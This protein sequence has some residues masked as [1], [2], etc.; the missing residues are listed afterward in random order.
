MEFVIGL[1][2]TEYENF[3][4]NHK[5][6]SHFL[7]SYYW[8]EISKEKNFMP[9]YV[10][11]KIDNVLVAAALILEKNPKGRATFFYIPRGYVIDFNNKELL[12]FFTDNIKKLAKKRHAF[13]IRIDPDVKLHNLDQ[14]GKVVD[15][16]NNVDLVNYLISL[17]F[18]HLGYNQNFEHNQPRY[19]FRL[20]LTPS[21]EEI[22]NNFHATTRKIINKGNFCNIEFYK[23]DTEVDFDDFYKTM[24]ETAIRE[25]INLLPLSYYK[26]FYNVLHKHNMSDLYLAKVNVKNLIEVYNAKIKALNSEIE[27]LTNS[28]NRNPEKT[29]N[30]INDLNNQKNKLISE[31][32]EIKK[33]EEDTLVLSSIITVKYN[34]KVWTVHGGNLSILRELNTNYLLYYQIIKDAKMDGYKKID[35]FGTTGN[36]DSNNSVYGIHLF[37]KRFGGEY[38]EF[39][40]EFDLVINKFLY[41]LY[42]KIMP[43]I[44][45]K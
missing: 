28:Q 35:F 19:T 3:V 9:H 41:L 2:E 10:G 25:D 4:F 21:L 44:R 8:G 42:N 7:Q 23:G 27:I 6:K 37:K 32:E 17:G 33:I 20:D 38:L 36:P 45:K 24:K 15:G 29:S 34:D 39:I 13:F 30:L 11:V 14:D 40:G 12:K 31:I 22:V 18:R 43:M 26:H 1:N 16:E 5:T